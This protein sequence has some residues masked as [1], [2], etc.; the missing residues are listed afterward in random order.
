MESLYGR[1]PDVDPVLLCLEDCQRCRGIPV[2]Q[3]CKGV[4]LHGCAGQIVSQCTNGRIMPDQ[5]Q[6]LNVVWSAVDKAVKRIEVCAIE[7]VLKFWRYSFRQS[8]KSTCSRF[9]CPPCGAAENLQ[10]MWQSQLGQLLTDLYGLLAAGF[11]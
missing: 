2:S 6:R 7:A 3:G 1:R 8:G 5:K 11:G 4:I 10:G 9:P